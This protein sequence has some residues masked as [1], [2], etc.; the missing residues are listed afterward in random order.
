MR[1]RRK[2]RKRGFRSKITFIMPRKQNDVM[3]LFGKKQNAGPPPSDRV[4]SMMRSGMS[5]KDIVR[6]LKSEGF[7]FGD[8]EKA[9]MAAVKEGASPLP[10]QASLQSN[11]TTLP[12]G[13]A[14]T[15]PS[16]RNTGPPQLPQAPAYYPPEPAPA[17]SQNPAYSTYTPED[18]LQPEVIMEEL[19][20]SVAEEKFEKFSNEI[21]IVKGDMERLR[22]QLAEARK[23]AETKPAPELPREL[24]ERLD[25]FESRLG[26]LEKAFKQFM[27]TLAENIGAISK[28]V[29]E[30]RRET[31]QPRLPMQQSP[32]TARPRPQQ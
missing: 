13:P 25:D 32:Q 6:Q 4:R 17:Y 8:I 7:S 21:K 20:E 15:P 31:F 12:P 27:P 30:R 28:L 5:E 14:Q 23:L 18:E 10:S 3:A 9:L 29:A 1:S 26:G 16:E 2:P 22:G 24:S 19:V 11:E